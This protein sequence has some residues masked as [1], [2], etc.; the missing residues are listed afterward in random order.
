M[1]NIKYL[2][3]VITRSSREISNNLSRFLCLNS[4]VSPLRKILAPFDPGA[5]GESTYN[6][7]GE[8]K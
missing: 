7:C 1:L 2:F 8:S 3:A 6:M 4:S 5:T